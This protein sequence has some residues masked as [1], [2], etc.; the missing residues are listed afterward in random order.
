MDDM[1]DLRF[2]TGRVCANER[3]GE[4]DG[5]PRCGFGGIIAQ[6]IEKVNGVFH[7]SPAIEAI[8]LTISV[9]YVMIP[10]TQPFW[11]VVFL[12]V[13]FVSRRSN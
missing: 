4:E 5:V 11:G 6:K 3:Y 9:F 8:L 13:P 10:P 7:T 12:S 1:G 2:Q